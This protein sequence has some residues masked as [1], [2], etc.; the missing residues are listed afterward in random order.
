MIKLKRDVLINIRK[1]IGPELVSPAGNWSS[2]KSAVSAGCDS[3]YFGIKD[4]NMRQGADNFDVLEMQKVMEFLH[5]NGKKGYLALNVIVFNKEIDK[6]KKILIEAKRC[7]VDAIILWDM[8][9]LT[10]CKELELDI[11]ISTQASVSNFEAFKFYAKLGAKRIVLAREC[12]LQDISEIH[13]QAK[14]ENIKCDIETFIHGAMCVSISGRC[15]L[16]QET[17][18]KSANRGECLQ[19]CR[20]EFKILDKENE[21]E[22]EIGE[23]YILSPK[24]M[25]TIAFIEELIKSGISAFKIEGR[26]RP[27]EYVKVVTSSYREAIDAYSKGALNENLKKKLFSRMEKVFNR[28]FSSGF[29]FGQPEDLGGTLQNKYEKTYVGIVNKFYKKIMVAE[30]EVNF[31]KIEKG[32][33]LLIS[34]KKTEANFFIANDME[35]D[36]V[37]VKEASKGEK[38]GI[39]IP[40]NANKNDKVFLWAD[41]KIEDC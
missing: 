40:F 9:V 6:I 15:F 20:R 41:E 28:G 1:N 21:C 18:K 36:H 39:K 13:K 33:K 24:D 16:S 30:I 27:G 10:I 4:I 5:T 19:P 25:C 11:H 22:Y 29:Y 32:Q 31:G 34:G 8:A 3:V 14:N 12:T 35:M 26:M 2:L 23:D 37:T 7:K 17:F 38:V